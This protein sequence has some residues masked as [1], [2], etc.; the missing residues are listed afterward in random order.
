MT[1]P[2]LKTFTACRSSRGGF[3]LVE[4]LVV[5]GIIA[6]LAGVA[7]GP[8]THGLETAKES[9]G[10]QTARTIA[11]AEF[12]YQTDNSNYPAGA[13][14]GAVAGALV[15]GGYITDVSIFAKDKASAY[16]GPTS[17][18]GAVTS[19]LDTYATICW[20]FMAGASNTTGLTTSDPDGLPLVFTTGQVVAVPADYA[21]A[22]PI[23]MVA[24][25]NPY[26]NN[27]MAVCFKSNSAS[28]LKAVN[29]G[30]TYNV[31]TSTANALF[32]PSFT[33][34]TGAVYTQIKP[35]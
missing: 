22:T 29:Q 30:G 1:H 21:A 18:A 3:T 15:S 5:I 16:T 26:G 19:G 35:E 14:S 20:D 23:P 10:M 24:A 33:A 32:G 28:F 4:L 6:I 34:P 31:Q 13:T 27:G 12:Q 2:P 25:N 8:I 17:T 9:A 7:L 11:L